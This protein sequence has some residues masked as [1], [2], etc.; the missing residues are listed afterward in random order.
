MPSLKGARN[1]N[2]AGRARAKAVRDA[3]KA[4]KTAQDDAQVA[5]TDDLGNFVA[6][7]KR[8]KKKSSV[9]YL[10]HIPHGFYEEQMKGFFSQFG[11]VKNVR[12]SRNKRTGRSKHFAF[13]EFE[14]PAVA[15]TVARAMDKYILFGRTLVCHVLSPDKVHPLLFK[16]ANKKFRPIPFRLIARKRHNKPKS[17]AQKKR[18]VTRLLKKEEK[19][20]KMLALMG[21]E[22]EFPGFRAAVE[23][24]ASPRTKAVDAA[25]G[26]AAKAAKRLAADEASP[27]E[28]LDAEQPE[29]AAAPQ[30][31][32]KKRKADVASGSAKR[33]KR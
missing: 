7:P 22:Y 9:I 17:E 4:V 3:K 27:E 6:L 18:I 5:E 13:I 24:L 19:K 16:G 20:R 21:I 33:R 11:T 12:L 30:E 29:P 10:G 32:K 2:A 31:K 28:A 23:A 15:D 25:K 1:A 26:G 14:S 8:S